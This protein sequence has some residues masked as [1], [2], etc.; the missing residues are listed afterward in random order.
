MKKKSILNIVACLI[1]IVSA[2]LAILLTSFGAIA[3]TINLLFYGSIGY[4][5]IKD[6]IKEDKE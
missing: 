3:T 6:F 4:L 5:F 2:T 1:Y